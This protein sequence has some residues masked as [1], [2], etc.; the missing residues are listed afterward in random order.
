MELLRTLGAIRLDGDRRDEDAALPLDEA[1]VPVDDAHSRFVRL[2]EKE[3]AKRHRCAPDEGEPR[4]RVFVEGIL[5]VEV[6]AVQRPVDEIIEVAHAVQ[7]KLQLLQRPQVNDLVLVVNDLDTD[8]WLL[9][10][11]EL[12]VLGVIELAEGRRAL[13]ERQGV[14]ELSFFDDDEL[15]QNLLPQLLA[16]DIRLFQDDRIRQH[17]LRHLHVA[18]LLPPLQNFIK[19]LH[20]LIAVGRGK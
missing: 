10:G 12:S 1:G 5:P 11:H 3:I 4:A 17:G 8:A 9:R 6:L 16:N 2:L 18:H 19:Q 20:F 14:R 15:I 7:S 13:P